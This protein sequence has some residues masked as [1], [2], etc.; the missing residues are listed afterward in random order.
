M[1]FPSYSTVILL[2]LTAMLHTTPTLAEERVLERGVFQGTIEE[3]QPME[4]PW[5]I[6]NSTDGK[7]HTLLCGDLYETCLRS[8]PGEVVKA[9][10]I[11]LDGVEYQGE[12]IEIWQL[13]KLEIIT[14]TSDRQLITTRKAAETLRV[15]GLQGDGQDAERAAAANR[16]GV[17]YEKGQHR[18]VRDAG[19]AAEWYRVSADAGNALAMHN[20]GDLY[21]KGLG[22]QT[23]AEQAFDWYQRAALAGHAIG[24]EDMGDCYLKGIGVPADTA[25][26]LIMYRK[27]ADMGRKTAAQKLKLFSHNQ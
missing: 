10:Y 1:R 11:H 7:R 16:L 27:A 19:T 15:I 18:L 22:V 4:G 25:K 2:S 6:I 23:D 8:L 9:S 13:E 5:L 24:Y 14:A 17:W 26:A 20:L 12:P 21:R 3:I